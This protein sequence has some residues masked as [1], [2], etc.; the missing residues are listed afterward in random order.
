MVALE[1]ADADRVGVDD[2]SDLDLAAPAA[3][4]GVPQAIIWL[5][6]HHFDSF[7]ESVIL[8]NYEVSQAQ[9]RI[10]KMV[11]LRPREA[12]SGWAPMAN[13]LRASRLRRRR[14]T[15]RVPWALPPL[16]GPK[17][18][19][20]AVEQRCDVARVLLSTAEKSHWQ[21]EDR[22]QACTAPSAFDRAR[23]RCVELL[24]EVLRRRL[25]AALTIIPRW[26]EPGAEALSVV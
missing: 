16:E 20:L 11:G 23:S 14:L 15:H 22:R 4:A 10:G 1:V 8:S 26:A 17:P 21:E 5:L 12:L 13:S 9:S 25:R 24:P 19:E 2:D 18:S 3:G 7:A 6:T